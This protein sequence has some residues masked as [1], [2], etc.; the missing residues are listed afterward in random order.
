M[1]HSNKTWIKILFSLS[2]NG[3]GKKNFLFFTLLEN[4]YSSVA[5]QV[6]KKFF[7]SVITSHE[8]VCLFTCES[9]FACFS[10]EKKRLFSL[11]LG[12]NHPC[13]DD[14]L[15][16]RLKHV[17]LDTK[18]LTEDMCV[19]VIAIFLLVMQEYW[20]RKLDAKSRFSPVERTMSAA[21]KF[22]VG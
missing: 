20:Q 14:T 1:L 5:L 4:L 7:L 12:K 11:L 8:T 3:K 18:Y 10:N 9:Y 19:C 21:Q 16:W 6:Q 15:I 2:K 13:S 22:R 17:R